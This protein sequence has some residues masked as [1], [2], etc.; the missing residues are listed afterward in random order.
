MA[1]FVCHW[2][3]AFTDRPFGGNGCAVVHNAAHLDDATCLSFVRETSL[4]EC[5]YLGPSDEA[6]LH[7][8][9]FLASREIP[10]AGHPT[11]ASVIAAHAAGTIG[12]GN[13]TLQTGAG[14]IPVHLSEDGKTVTMR[15]NAPEFGPEASPDLVAAT[16]GVAVEDLAAVPQVVSTGLPFVITVLKDPAQQSAAHLD[17]EA[18][19]QLRA[20][21]GVENADVMEPFIVT[22]GGAS[23]Q[24]DTF[25][26]LLLAPPNPPED[27][28]T[29]SATGAMAAYLWAKGLIDTPEFVA[30][31]RHLMGRPGRAQVRVIGGPSAI[32]A[33]EVSGQGHILMSGHLHL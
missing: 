5:T 30:E 4:V 22:L 32:K 29:G 12:T 11:V 21:L 7:V 20:S 27:P 23:A 18:L 6:D 1:D 19:S 28:F 9:Y 14:L 17:V 8:R 33:V 3:D 2:V 16:I 26:R 15:Q 10:F 31:Q 24:G 13:L 25:A